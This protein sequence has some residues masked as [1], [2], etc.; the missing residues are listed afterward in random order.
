[1][2]GPVIALVERRKW[3]RFVKVRDSGPSAIDL[4]RPHAGMSVQEIVAINATTYLL[5]RVTSGIDPRAR[6]RRP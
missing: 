5:A 2:N 1:M 4:E 3:M 6:A